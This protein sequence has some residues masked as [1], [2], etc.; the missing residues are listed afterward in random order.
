M[1]Y[2]KQFLIF[3]PYAGGL[4]GELWSWLHGLLQTDSCHSSGFWVCFDPSFNESYDI[5][6]LNFVSKLR[7]KFR[8]CFII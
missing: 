4:S 1:L 6:D 8:S 7:P 5:T 3:R 2:H